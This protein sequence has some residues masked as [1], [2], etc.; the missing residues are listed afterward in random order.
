[1]GAGLSG[2]CCAIIL[3]QNGIE[4]VIFE[5]RNLCGDRFINGEAIFNIT[6]RP[7]N[8]C[9][10]FFK[11]KYN[12]NLKPIS[13]VK[14]ITIYSPNFESNLS[15]NLGYTNYR[16][17]HKDSFEN[18]LFNQVK[19][20]IIFNSNYDYEDL[21]KEFTHVVLATGDSAYASKLNNFKTDLTVNLRG[22]TVEGNFGLSHIS[23]WYNNEFSPKGYSYLIPLNER[24]AN[25]SIGYPV[26][27]DTKKY[28]IDD[29]WDKFYKRAQKDTEQKLNIID[30][31]EV[32]RYIIGI[33]HKAKLDNTYFIGNCF[34]AISPGFG[35]GQFVSVLTGIYAAFDICSKGDYEELVVPLRETYENSL[36]FR[37][38][39]EKLSNNQLDFLIGGI[40]DKLISKM[41]SD[42]TEIDFFK[43]ASKLLKPFTKL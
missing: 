35:L 7:I 34:G 14:E 26:Y 24:E 39:L 40:N 8:N 37:R 22:A 10:D 23:S 18:Q 16:G 21:T 12:I 36:V 13:E 31:F 1:M 9:L 30:K 17:R 33:C 41:F 20:E 27:E 28:K 43:I 19:S 15:G 25:I 4:P 11:D 38:R 29:L 42:D 6:N 5:K 2:L 3:E 32:E